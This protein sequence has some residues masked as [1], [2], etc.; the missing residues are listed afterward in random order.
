VKTSY[1]PN[2][3]VDGADGPFRVTPNLMVVVPT[4]E[5]VELHYGRTPVD[6]LAW[7]L[8]AMGLVAV[9]ALARRPTP[10]MPTVAPPAPPEPVA[11]GPVGT[12]LADSGV[13]DEGWAPAVGPGDPD[14][15]VSRSE[16]GPE[17]GGGHPTP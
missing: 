5:H 13:D 10:T 15:P 16:S 17:P 9:V 3:E 1:F 2:W 7:A 4:A 6:L 8:T 14:V 12:G 11:A